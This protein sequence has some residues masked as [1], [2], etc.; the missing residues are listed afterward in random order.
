[1]QIFNTLDSEKKA[2]IR[3]HLD[4][5]I[6][7]NETVNLT[8]I[9]TLED[10]MV[11]HVEDSLIGL[12]ELGESPQ[13][14]YGDL[15]SGAGYPGIPLAIASERNTVLIDARQKKMIAMNAIIKELGIDDKVETY[16]G[17]AE[18][19]ARTR[20]ESFSVL[21]ARALAKLSVL[22]ELASPLLEN[23]GRLICYKANVEEE[24][25]ADARRVQKLTGMVLKSE[26]SVVLEEKFSR[27]IITF[28][29]KSRPTVKLPRQEGQAQKS[30]L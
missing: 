13:G 7:A 16:S 24:E 29:K 11:L 22:M 1:M 20:G 2:L 23:G 27:K 10:G 26:R 3:K 15:G 12:K 4:L 9:T 30:P 18:L 8:R 6:K 28:E 5:V 19:L 17:R 25:L 14:L 21:T